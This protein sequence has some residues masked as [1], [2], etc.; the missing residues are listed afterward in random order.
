MDL[1][2]FIDDYTLK[3]VKNIVD[4]V[5]KTKAKRDG[6]KV[7]TLNDKRLKKIKIRKN[8]L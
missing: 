6:L 5:L 3:I 2:E 4:K 1:S 8:I 7:P